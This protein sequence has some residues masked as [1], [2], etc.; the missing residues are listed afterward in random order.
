MSDQ[1]LGTTQ[2]RAIQASSEET[3][4]TLA[5]IQE[6]LIEMLGPVQEL[7]A[8]V[9]SQSESIRHGFD[10]SVRFS[11]LSAIAQQRGQIGAHES[12]VEEE[13]HQLG[14]IRERLEAT[15]AELQEKSSA[16]LEKID[17]RVI[18]TIDQLDGP[19]L[20]LG[21]EFFENTVYRPQEEH[22]KPFWQLVPAL[23]EGSSQGRAESLARKVRALQE[24]IHAF[25]QETDSLRSKT[26]GFRYAEAL[27]SAV[28]IPVC[29]VEYREGDS[30]RLDVIVAPEEAETG[31]LKSGFDWSYETIEMGIRRAWQQIAGQFKSLSLSKISENADGVAARYFIRFKTGTN[32]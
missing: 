9:K 1:E 22:I 23:G 18:R 24:R 6:Q 25:R 5:A 20:D 21:R 15:R 11:L 32:S 14:S 8:L 17:K 26:D 29:V 27:P 19:V 13:Q 2:L 4:R 31:G 7:P 16:E 12:Q 10:D 30:V 28:T 3:R